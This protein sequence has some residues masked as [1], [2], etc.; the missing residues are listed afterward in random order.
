MPSRVERECT[1]GGTQFREKHRRV[2][3]QDGAGKMDVPCFGERFVKRWRAQD[4]WKLT[5]CAGICEECAVL[6]SRDSDGDARGL[7]QG[8]QAL[9]LYTKKRQPVANPSG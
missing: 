2:F 1:P 4:S 7:V 3:P 8:D 6:G 5:V 9:H